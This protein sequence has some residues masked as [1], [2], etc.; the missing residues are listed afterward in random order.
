MAAYKNVSGKK[1]RVR[2]TLALIKG[3][4]HDFADAM[5]TMDSAMDPR[6]SS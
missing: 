6:V 1:I 2:G 5:A 3:I 4:L